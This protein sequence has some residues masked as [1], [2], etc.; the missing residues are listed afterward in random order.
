MAEL[1]FQV[2]HDRAGL[3]SRARPVHPVHEAEK[4]LTLDDGR[5]PDHPPRPGVLRLG[6]PR[7]YVLVLIFAARADI[8]PCSDEIRIVLDVTLCLPEYDIFSLHT[9]LPRFRRLLTSGASLSYRARGA[10]ELYP[11]SYVHEKFVQRQAHSTGGQ[12]HRL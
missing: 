7:D 10:V 11:R 6:R 12:R 5:R 2:A 1:L 9:S 8:L 4:H 3:V